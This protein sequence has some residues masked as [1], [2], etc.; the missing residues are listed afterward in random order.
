MRWYISV[1]TLLP[2]ACKE[3][4]LESAQRTFQQSEL[5]VP[6]GPVVE[7][8]VKV[9][10]RFERH[11]FPSF[12]AMTPPP[13]TCRWLDDDPPVKGWIR[14]IGGWLTS[15]STEHGCYVPVWGASGLQI[16]ERKLIDVPKG[17]IPAS[18]GWP[19][20]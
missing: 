5:L 7:R 1:N 3:D 19:N 11:R 10:D 16:I 13:E 8:D 12:G 4:T 2:L 17:T 6:I 14:T 15:E 20:G 18:Q 9:G